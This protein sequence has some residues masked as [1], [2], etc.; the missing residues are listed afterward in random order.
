MRWIPAFAGMTD[1]RMTLKKEILGTGF[2]WYD[3]EGK[4]DARTGIS[5]PR[6][7]VGMQKSLQCRVVYPGMQSLPG[8][9]SLG[10]N[11]MDTC[12][13]RYDRRKN[14]PEKR[15]SGYRLSP[16]RRGLGRLASSNIARVILELL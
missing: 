12:L 7:C 13:R 2:R 1:G 6:S 3:V 10:M 16:V 5:F 4:R 14:D 9:G 8:Y 11:A 15:N